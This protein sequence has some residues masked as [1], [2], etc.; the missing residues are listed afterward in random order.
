[1]SFIN[2]V[3]LVGQLLAEPEMRKSRNGNE[4][5][6]IRMRTGRPFKKGWVYQ[7]HRIVC[8]KSDFFPQIK[9]LERGSWIKVMGE[10]TYLNGGSSAQIT[11]GN[12]FGDIGFMFNDVWVPDAEMTDEEAQLLD[13]AAAAPQDSDQASK[14]EAE[15]GSG[16]SSSEANDG[17][18]PQADEI[19]F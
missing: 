3:R 8:F 15:Q 19:P 10:L 7:E 9:K 16:E 12:A 13:Q 1:M 17:T 2:D 11:V 4:F 6:V 18:D 5:A 14:A